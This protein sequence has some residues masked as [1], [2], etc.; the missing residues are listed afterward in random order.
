VRVG[1]AGGDSG[2]DLQSV[3][4][5]AR[6]RGTLAVVGSLVVATAFGAVERSLSLQHSDF[7]AAVGSLTAPWLLLPFLVGT[8]RPRREGLRCWGSHCVWLAIGACSAGAE[9]GGDFGGHLTP[10]RIVS[11]LGNFGLSHLPVLLGAAV[12]DRGL[13]GPGCRPSP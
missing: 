9:T 11:Y 6:H 7:L 1:T 5:T 13:A 12:T 8:A 2:E 10:D 3:T 4:V